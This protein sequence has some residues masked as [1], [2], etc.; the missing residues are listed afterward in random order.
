VQAVLA[1]HPR[2][3]EAV[4]IAYGDDPGGKRLVAYYTSAGADQVQAAELAA[5]CAQRLPDYMV[6]GAFV[7]LDRI[8]L[9]RNGKLDRRGLPAPDRASLWSAREFVPPRT[10]TERRLA[11]IWAGLLG[12]DRVGAH[13]RFMDLGGDSLMVLRALSQARTAGLPV[14]LRMIYQYGSIAELA[15]AI[16]RASARLAAD[17]HDGRPLQLTPAQRILL[18]RNAAGQPDQYQASLHIARPVDAQTLDAA[19]RAV[20]SHHDALRLRIA[21]ADRGWHVTIADADEAGPVRQASAAGRRQRG[22][23]R[24]DQPVLAERAVNERAVTELGQRLD[25]ADGPVLDALLVSPDG[26]QPARLA[27]AAHALVMDR[28]SWPALLEDLE[29]AYRQ[30]AQGQEV[31][32]PPA[33]T[34]FGPWAGQLADM[35]AGTGLAGQAHHWLNL[36]PGP[37]LPVDGQEGTALVVSAR[38]ITAALP[39]G[40]ADQLRQVPADNLRELMLA[41]LAVVLARW[42]GGDR[43]LVDIEARPQRA[44]AAGKDLSRAVGPFTHR[45]PV[46]LW[47]PPR[48]D[49]RAVLRSVGEQLRAV[50]DDGLGYGM[51][52]HL[53][54]DDTLA[55]ALARMPSPAVRFGFAQS[56]ARGAGPSGTFTLDDLVAIRDP[57]TVREHL[58][59]V[60]VLAEAAQIRSSWTYSPAMHHEATI[61]RLMTDYAAELTTMADSWRAAEA[62]AA[63]ARGGRPRSA[64]A[65]SPAPAVMGEHHVPGVSLATIRG[66]ELVSVDAYGRVDA[67]GSAPVTSQTLFRVASVSKQVTALGV[68]R[69]VT[70]GRLDLD[71]DVNSYLVS[72]QIPGTGQSPVTARHLLANV[73]G[74]ATEPDHEA[75]RHDEPLP[76]A[77]EALAGR[78]PARTPPVRPKCPPGQLFEKN[79]NNYLVLDLLMT[80]ITGCTFP[81]LM[82]ELVFEPL[83]M[84]NSSF[85]PSCP[86]TASQPVARGHDAFGI[87]VAELGPAHP[88]IAAGGLWSTAED[89]AKAQL[90]I[91]R[92]YLGQPALI[93]QSLAEQMLTPTPGTLYG[94]STVV[95]QSPADLDFGSVGEF[96]GYF[97]VAMCRIRSGD[98]FGLLANADG[99]REIARI[100]ADPAAD[101]GE[102][103]RLEE[104]RRIA[105]A[106]EA[107]REP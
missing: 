31:V 75:Y 69:L 62:S 105:T 46:A 106:T 48:Q 21:A 24:S 98:G 15:E 50:P 54:V 49:A 67:R 6:P 7:A 10:G 17:G 58:L 29:T 8:P 90:E 26:G 96:T 5:H 60:D 19:L 63:A 1:S 66:G 52:R 79:K 38:T 74:L 71:K 53:A 43:L 51:L 13:D 28:A 12:V 3:R 32:L 99:G 30:L 25:I 82:K 81:Q 64:S 100:M 80:H 107:G 88:A 42:A 77:L 104:A 41:A 20:I 40:L 86:T 94:L 95:D 18:D 57:M 89:L 47:I 59:E 61:R 16:D 73:A 9:T 102:F 91:R 70:E 55:S 35:A 103:G 93:T 34:E 83:G 2:V 56:P 72:W 101:S 84:V 92:A 78:H 4:V 11:G 44:A 14:S 36:V 68:L 87:P 85:D 33:S 97:A 76:T 37:P 45:F 23:T 39:A 22:R 27:I 65:A